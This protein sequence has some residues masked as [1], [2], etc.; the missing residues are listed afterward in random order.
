MRE[1]TL[2]IDGLEIGFVFGALGGVDGAIL[3]REALQGPR[4]PSLIPTIQEAERAFFAV[5]MVG[6]FMT[7]KGQTL[8]R[9]E[10][11][12]EYAELTLTQ[13][14][15]DLDSSDISLAR[16]QAQACRDNITQL[17]KAALIESVPRTKPGRA[18]FVYL[19]QSSTGYYK[20][21]RTSDPNNRMKTFSVKLPFEV[22][23]ACVIETVDMKTLE[24]SLH[25]QFAGKRVNGEWFALDAADV[26]YIRGL[27][28]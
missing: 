11:Q 1:A 12:L 17:R 26:E 16:A 22:S 6:E 14:F 4:L 15:F 23:Y 5:C 24:Q 20:I 7:A 28:S 2:T 3:S 9:L 21:G 27:A 18:G 10:A 25:E 13:K 19:V 8:E